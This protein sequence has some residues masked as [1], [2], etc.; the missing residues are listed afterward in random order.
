MDALAA[1]VAF[2]IEKVCPIRGL[3]ICRSADKE[4]WQIEF[5]EEASEEQRETAAGIVEG[6]DLDAPPVPAS[7]SPRQA[8]LAIESAGLT[9][10]VEAAVESAGTAARIAWDYALEVRRD[11]P[12]LVQLATALGL[13]DGDLD[14]LFV[15]AAA[16]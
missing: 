12:L 14:Q 9:A 11:D 2:A 7:V 8:R 16:R 3:R 1:R 10:Q 15:A 5:A 13:S 4:T 6:F